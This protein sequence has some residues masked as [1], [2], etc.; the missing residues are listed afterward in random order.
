MKTAGIIAE[1]NPF[2]KGHEYQIRYT[3]E[4]LKA[5]Y[6][7]VAMSGD[8]VQRGT[9]A[10]TSKHARA[11][12]ALRCGAD[13]VLEMPVSISTASAEA[14]A[15]GGVSL[16]DSL[17]VVDILCFGSESGEISAL[18]ELAEILVEEPEEYKKLL[19]SFLSEGL[20]FPA[21]RSQAL[22]EYFKNPRNFNGDDF[23]GVLTP[24]L[25]EVTQILNTPNNILGIEYC[26][27]LLRLNSKIRPVTIRRE[28]MGY[29]ETT[30]PD[31][32]STVASPDLQSPTDFF[33]SATAIRNLILQDSPDPDSLAPQ[34]PGQAFPV[35]QEAVNSGEFLTENSLDSI[36]SYCLMK[37]NV[38]SLSS[39]MDVSDDL[40]RRIINQQ[41]LLLSF[42]QSV[43][44]LKTKE[45]T[46]TRIQRALLHIILNIHTA[47]TQIP[48]A[49]VLGFRR[50]SSE[51]LSQ[52]KQHSRIPLITKLADA[53]NFL[54]NEGNQ[55][56]SE[57]VFSSNLYEKLL[58]LK[59]GRKFC[60]ES[61]KQIIIL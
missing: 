26:K 11:E 42:S 60:H 18:K 44:V 39:Y 13:L 19:K 8:Y 20:T 58:C 47:P 29:H 52:I 25:N 7:I 61:Q 21:A 51:L 31:E 1:Y 15:M 24:L 48:F 43:S 9:P 56:L 14:F 4:R 36:L 23:D 2:H 5:D 28:G 50:E 12:M 37:E 38:K 45:L 34:I 35:F 6:V 27:A 46:Q 53:Q 22:T 33:A 32:N 57:T 17:G 49:R 40:A 10:L 55:I 41:N 16:L 30:V 54:D 59:T 3:K